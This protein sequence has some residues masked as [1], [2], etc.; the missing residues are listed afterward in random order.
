MN[1]TEKIIRAKNLLQLLHFVT[2]ELRSM[3]QEGFKS[4]MKFRYQIIISAMKL[5]KG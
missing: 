1:C 2:I 4:N 5:M 3:A